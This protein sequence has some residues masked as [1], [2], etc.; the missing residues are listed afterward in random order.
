METPWIF[1]TSKLHRKEYVETTL[2]FRPSKLHRKKYMEITWIFGP[3]KLRQKSAWKQRG[4]FGHRNYIEK[5]C[6]NDV[7]IHRNLVI[8]VS[9]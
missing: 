8:D 3:A 9:T 5:V 4:F 1:Q 6:G 7:E 2:I